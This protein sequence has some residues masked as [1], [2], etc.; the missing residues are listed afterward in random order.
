VDKSFWQE[1]IKQQKSSGQTI[2]RYCREHGL[3]AQALYNHRSKFKK[4][5]KV[6]TPKTA[7]SFN[8]QMVKVALP[9]TD[10]AC[11]SLGTIELHL[12]DRIKIISSDWPPA[13]VLKSY[14]EVL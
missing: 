2:T 13:E 3:S 9:T 8:S 11:S 10:Q 1:H 7:D 6:S 12:S 14:R 5:S 4:R